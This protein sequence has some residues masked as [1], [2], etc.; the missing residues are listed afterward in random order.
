MTA[1]RDPLGWPEADCRTPA[2]AVRAIL[3]RLVELVPAI[4]LHSSG[5]SWPTTVLDAGCG[6]GAIADV[7][8]E[9]YSPDALY[10]VD[11]RGPAGRMPAGWWRICTDWLRGHYN[12]PAALVVSNPP[13]TLPGWRRGPYVPE[14]DGVLRFTRRA[15]EVAPVACI[16][17]RSGWWHEQQRDRRAFRAELRARFVTERWAVGRVDFFE[18]LS[19]AEKRALGMGSGDSTPYAWL[20]ARPPTEA[21][22]PGPWPTREFDCVLGGENGLGRGDA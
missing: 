13:F 22:G 7:L 16:L 10:G 12:G 8:A 2:W 21:D 5:E 15:L 4:T 6:T 3:P 19:G 11:V 18:H 20:I 14:F 9:A 1:T 17:H